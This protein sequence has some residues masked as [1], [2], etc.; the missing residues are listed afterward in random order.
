MLNA[1]QKLAFLSNINSKLLENH[2]ITSYEYEIFKQIK[3]EQND[4]GNISI[5]NFRNNYK[6]VG[7]ENNLNEERMGN[8]IIQEK[9]KANIEKI[10]SYISDKKEYEFISDFFISEFDPSINSK[11]LKKNSSINTINH[12]ESNLSE[13]S[14]NNNLKDFDNLNEDIL[15]MLSKANLI[16]INSINKFNEEINKNYKSKNSEISNISSIKYKKNSGLTEEDFLL[17]EITKVKSHNSINN[18]GLES[19]E[20]MDK[21]LEEEINRQIFGY[22][23]KM[24]ESARNFGAQLKKDNQT[25]NKIENLQDQVNAKTTKQVKR[26]EEFNYS[27]K[28]GF[29]KL[30]ILLFTVIGSFIGTMFIIK[31]FPK[32]A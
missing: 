16:D 2:E 20:E 26:L 5:D 21:E 1:E 17:P 30:M 13:N 4:I 18:N 31:I 11:F 9:I 8:K 24:K 32:L 7:E 27:I 12:S 29:C 23:K 28:I 6:K 10:L 19:K 14:I 15:N 22:T 25:L 3:L